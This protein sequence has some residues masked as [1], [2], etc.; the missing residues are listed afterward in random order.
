MFPLFRRLYQTIRLGITTVSVSGILLDNKYLTYPPSHPLTVLEPWTVEMLPSSPPPPC[1]YTVLHRVTPSFHLH[2]LNQFGPLQL[3]IGLG[4]QH[5]RNHY[6]EKKWKKKK[7]EENK[8]PNIQQSY[9]TTVGTV[10]AGYR[11]D[12]DDGNQSSPRC[13]IRC[14]SLLFLV[15]TTYT[16]I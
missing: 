9:Q 10:C 16:P 5:R 15:M 4:T 6:E 13:P 14:S 8:N 12:S 7:S 2:I 11:D 1:S 3:I